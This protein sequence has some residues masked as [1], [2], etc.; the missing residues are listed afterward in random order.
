MSIC[1]SSK[2]RKLQQSKLL[3]RWHRTLRPMASAILTSRTKK[4]PILFWAWIALASMCTRR[5]RGQIESHRNR[6]QNGSLQLFSDCRLSP[7]IN[8]PWSEIN[9]ISCQNNNFIVKLTDKK[10]PKFVVGT[11]P[12][13]Q[14]VCEHND[15]DIIT[16]FNFRVFAGQSR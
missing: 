6:A 2:T 10:S 1:C 5:R 11:D 3:L 8:F 13:Y 9:R 4:G 14:N 16:K 12:F 7:Q 15:K